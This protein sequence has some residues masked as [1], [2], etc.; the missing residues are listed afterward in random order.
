MTSDPTGEATAEAFG[1]ALV[2]ES[3][4]RMLEESLP[5]I[6]KCLDALSDEEIWRQPNDET[7]SIGNLVLHLCGNV[8]QWIVSGLGGA[9]DPRDRDA[10]FAQRGT[11]PK[12]DLAVRLEDTLREAAEAM[13]RVDAASLL[14]TRRV[15]GQTETGLSILVHVVEHFSYHT[16]QISLA[17]KL[18]K[19]VDLGYYAGQDLN[20]KK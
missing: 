13:D 11:I 1:A 9:E 2:A 15:Q 10:E 16:G 12:A 6:K 20:A 19:G 3:K 17:V 18:L 5:R 8:R 7:V 14:E 4:R